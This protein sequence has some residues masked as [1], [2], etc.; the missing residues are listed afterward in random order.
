MSGLLD[1]GSQ[2]KYP[3][4]ALLR[5]GANLRLCR[6][7]ATGERFS[8]YHD[9]IPLKILESVGNS[10]FPTLPPTP[11]ILLVEGLT[12]RFNP[13]GLKRGDLIGFSKPTDHNRFVCK[14]ILGVAGDTVCIDPLNRPSDHV[15]VP[16]G[17][18]WVGGDNMPYSVDSRNYGPVPLGLV[19][20]RIL[21]SVR[22][23]HSHVT[24]PL[25]R[26]PS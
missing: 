4:A 11:S 13:T 26:S 3:P 15:T 24:P 18:V 8:Q 25:S 9:R 16:Q 5:L 7:P 2:L 10:M 19:K 20:T 22:V 21:A 12:P 17:H 6:G 14:R 1:L 23:L